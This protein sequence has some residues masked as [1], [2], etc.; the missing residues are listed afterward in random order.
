MK[1]HP[2]AKLAVEVSLRDL[3]HCICPVSGDI[4]KGTKTTWYGRKYVGIPLEYVRPATLQEWEAQRAILSHYSL[5]SRS[6]E[7]LPK[8]FRPWVMK[9]ALL[10]SEA[11]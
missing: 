6:L 9:R 1:A 10:K 5:T 11:E 4:R 2:T 3:E 7:V 8:M